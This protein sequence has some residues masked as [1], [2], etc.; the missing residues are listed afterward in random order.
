M[1]HHD[2]NKY[3][4]ACGVFLYCVGKFVKLFSQLASGLSIRLRFLHLSCGVWASVECTKYT[5][6]NKTWELQPVLDK[7]ANTPLIWIT[8]KVLINWL[9]NKEGDLSLFSNTGL[10]HYKKK[11]GMWR[12]DISFKGGRFSVCEH[13]Y[14]L[15]QNLKI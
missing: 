1:S 14:L 9:K 4:T 8:K 13:L 10:P 6:S 15:L 5:S 12:T 11:C 2:N 7:G 3:I